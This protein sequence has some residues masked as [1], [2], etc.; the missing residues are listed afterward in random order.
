M[1]QQPPKKWKRNPKLLSYIV[2]ITQHLVRG[3]K[4]IRA[5][6]LQPLQGEALCFIVGAVLPE[7]SPARA[8]SD[9]R[10]TGASQPGTTSR[11]LYEKGKPQALSAS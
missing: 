1:Q 5:P 9:H 8:A 2:C 7:L 10:T 3:P 4:V 11:G 6:P